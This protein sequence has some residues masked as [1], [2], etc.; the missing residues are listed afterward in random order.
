M[1]N[2]LIID[3]FTDC[4]KGVNGS[5][6]GQYRSLVSNTVVNVSL[7]TIPI[8]DDK[9]NIIGGV[10]L[11]EDVTERSKVE[12]AL[13]LSENRYRVLSNLTTDAASILT[14][15]TGGKFD[16]KWLNDSLLIKT[17]YSIQ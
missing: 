2:S 15:D 16:R 3:S 9:G 11:A 8:A 4:L 6:N 10:G 5:Y 12:E 7:R 13:L 17:G 14:I 1:N